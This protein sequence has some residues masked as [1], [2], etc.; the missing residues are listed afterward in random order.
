MRGRISITRVIAMLV[1]ILVL[2][3]GCASKGN[4]SKS[5]PPMLTITAGEAEIQAKRTTYSWWNKG[6]GV[7][8]DGPHPLDMAENLP[9]IEVPESETVSFAFEKDPDEVTVLAWKASAAGTGAYEKPEI[10]FSVS[11]NFTVILPSDGR[12][13]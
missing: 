9:V 12:Y 4:R 10:S 7:E 11:E 8:A 3:T 6:K 5:E 2:L 13:L 1:T